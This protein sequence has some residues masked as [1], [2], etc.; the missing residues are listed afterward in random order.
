[1]EIVSQKEVNPPLDTLSIIVYII[2]SIVVIACLIYL[3]II[4]F[5]ERKQKKLSLI[6]DLL[7]TFSLGKF[8][9][10]WS[11]IG[12]LAVVGI[13]GAIQLEK[14]SDKQ[15]YMKVKGEAV[16]QNYESSGN[17]L[18]AHLKGK[19]KQKYDIYL[20]KDDELN[21][22]HR[23]RRGDKV[24][25]TSEDKAY[26]LRER[27]SNLTTNNHSYELAKNSYMEKVDK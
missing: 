7:P 27:E 24:V 15:I 22:K 5:K 16:L 11:A 25:I 4:S 3:V 8:I 14:S 6:S 1:M 9:I 17:T 19:N 20:S 10:F 12:I 18:I 26:Q 23:I 13:M 21:Q 2:A